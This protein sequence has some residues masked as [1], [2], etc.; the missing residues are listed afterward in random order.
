MNILKF[1]LGDKTYNST[2]RLRLKLAE[3]LGRRQGQLAGT[4]VMEMAGLRKVLYLCDSCHTK[5]SERSAGY[6][7]ASRPPLNQGVI[8]NCDGC[9]AWG[10][11][12]VYLPEERFK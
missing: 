4:F 12:W 5:F 9:R 7:R 3:F 8:T 2:P 11:A 10:D 6:R 1:G